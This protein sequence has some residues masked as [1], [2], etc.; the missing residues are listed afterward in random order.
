MNA[1]NVNVLHARAE[2][3]RPFF[4]LTHCA[5][6]LMRNVEARNWSTAMAAHFRDFN[7][8]W[9]IIP[10]LTAVPFEEQ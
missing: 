8:E 7:F 6:L 3:I 10:P 1:V 4:N 9:H 2:A 5:E